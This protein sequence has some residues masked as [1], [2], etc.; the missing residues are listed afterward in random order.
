M[1]LF[2]NVVLIVTGIGLTALGF[3][4]KAWNDSKGHRRK[5]I[6]WH[7][8]ASIALFFVAVAFGAWKERRAEV[9]DAKNAQRADESRKEAVQAQD[10]LIAAQQQFGHRLTEAQLDV[11]AAR[12]DEA[13]AK[14]ALNQ[15]LAQMGHVQHNLDQV[16]SNAQRQSDASLITAF[17]NSDQQVRQVTIEIPLTAKARVSTSVADSL[18]PAFTDRKCVELTGVKVTMG[19]IKNGDPYSFVYPPSHTLA[20]T[21]YPQDKPEYAS[22]IDDESHSDDKQYI[23]SYMKM[24]DQSSWNGLLYHAELKLN[25]ADTSA[26]AFY[27]A[28]ITAGSEPFSISAEFPMT[29]LVGDSM[30]MD[31][32]DPWQLKLPSECSGRIRDYFT[33]A[34][35]HAALTVVLNQKQ[36]EVIIFP[37]KRVVPEP[38]G[39]GR[40]WVVRFRVSGPPF[41]G[42]D[43]EMGS[44]LTDL[45]TEARSPTKK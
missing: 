14:G 27:G 40:G 21:R 5:S 30:P 10:R 9:S 11:Q 26:A 17:A 22:R 43:A 8:W 25:G 12:V 31:Y 15:L 13:E 28:L 34:F 20:S 36:R 23:T 37:L 2:I 18:L 19:T 41:I 7:G 42:A 29:P 4:G 16:T 39:G 33:T 1:N 35:D 44:L 45:G 38:I 3:F 24:I 32:K 6:S